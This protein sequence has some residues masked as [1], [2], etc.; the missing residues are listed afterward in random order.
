MATI[1]F[2]KEGFDKAIAAGGITMVDFWASWCGPCRMLS[3]TVDQVAEERPDVMVG[4]VNVDEQP[5]LAQAFGVMSIPTLV[6]LKGGKTVET[7]VGVKPKA[8]VLAM[9]DK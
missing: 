7:S 1:H 2:N 8:V 5:E 9:L 6:V 4:K 3:P